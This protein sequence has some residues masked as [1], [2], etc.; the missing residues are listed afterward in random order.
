DS[1]CRTMSAVLA[2][3]VGRRV[4]PECS[5][6]G[7]ARA[8]VR[9]APSGRQGSGALLGGVVVPAQRCLAPAPAFPGFNASRDLVVPG[10]RHCPSAAGEILGTAR[11]HQS[12]PPVAAAGQASRSTGVA[13]DVLRLVHRGL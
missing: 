10:P 5:T 1:V 6:R 8:P 11:G 7:G 2:R 13:G 9:S 3:T 12:G 4:W